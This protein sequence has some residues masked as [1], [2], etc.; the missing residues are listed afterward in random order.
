MR[1]AVEPRTG[2]A[3]TSSP[4]VARNRS[5]SGPCATLATTL[6]R[7]ALAISNFDIRGSL[8]LIVLRVGAAVPG[9]AARRA[10][11]VA[12]VGGLVEE[13]LGERAARPAGSAATAR[14]GGRRSSCRGRRAGSSDRSAARRRSAD[15]GRWR[16]TSD[17]RR[18]RS[19]EEQP[20]PSSV[21]SAGNGRRLKRSAL[22]DFGRRVGGRLRW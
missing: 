18:R 1:T 12:A 11:V 2:S 19:I 9:V 13:V 14:R 4:N 6:S 16:T 15:R 7:S 3:N 8:R 5:A 17:P 10:H 20:R 22:N 21:I